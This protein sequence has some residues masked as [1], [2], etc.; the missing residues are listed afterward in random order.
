MEPLYNIESLRFFGPE[1]GL[2]GAVLLVIIWDLLAKAQRP[3]VFGAAAIAVAALAYSAL[4]SASFLGV[5]PKNLF[6]GLLAFD[7]FAHTFRIL[8]A[9]VSA[10]IILFATP[11]MLATTTL[12]R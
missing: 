3:K 11:A 4:A 2:I 6:N 10:L 7:D 5:E 9:F 8:F 12:E 1:L